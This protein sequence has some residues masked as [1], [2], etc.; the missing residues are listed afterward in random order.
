MSGAELYKQDRLWS[1]KVVNKC[2][3]QFESSS[4]LK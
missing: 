4:Q 2:A 3:E 1:I